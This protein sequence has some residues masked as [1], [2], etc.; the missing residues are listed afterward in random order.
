MVLSVK[1]LYTQQHNR[2]V[3]VPSERKVH[4]EVVVQRYADSCLVPSPFQNLDILGLLHPNLGHV[5]RIPA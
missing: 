1:T 4:M 5:N 3:T 2:G